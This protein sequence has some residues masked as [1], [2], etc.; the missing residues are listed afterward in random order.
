MQTPRLLL[1]PCV[2]ASTPSWADEL[3]RVYAGEC[4]IV[5]ASDRI[6][7]TAYVVSAQIDLFD[8]EQFVLVT[9]DRVDLAGLLDHL[10]DRERP[11]TIVLHISN[12]PLSD[13][14]HHFADLVVY[15]SETA[16]A[17]AGEAASPTAVIPSPQ[18]LRNLRPGSRATSPDPR[19]PLVLWP[20]DWAEENEPAVLL[21]ALD[22]L[23]SRGIEFRLALTGEHRDEVSPAI[24]TLLSR[25][26]EYIEVAEPL[27][28]EALDALLHRTDVVV[29]T[30]PGTSF[31]N[32][33]VE[34]MATGTYAVL[35]RRG[36][37]HELVPADLQSDCLFPVGGLA[38][39][40]MVALTLGERRLFIGRHLAAHARHF[41]ASQVAQRWLD[42]TTS[43][44]YPPQEAISSSNPVAPNKDLNGP[45]A[46]DT[47]P[48]DEAFNSDL[49]SLRGL[50]NLPALDAPLVESLEV[51]ESLDSTESLKVAETI[52][53][54]EAPEAVASAFTDFD[55]TMTFD[56][57][58]KV[59]VAQTEEA[60][61]YAELAPTDWDTAPFENEA[62]LLEQ[63]GSEPESASTSEVEPVKPNAP[64][65]WFATADER[66]EEAWS[67]PIV[68]SAFEFQVDERPARPSPGL[69]WTKLSG[70]AQASS[71]KP[72]NQLVWD[73][74]PITSAN[75]V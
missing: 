25:F 60:A 17:A 3:A 32:S 52:E 6:A 50:A 12:E 31:A 35:S 14:L 38:R 51:D 9:D 47:V 18:S 59:G 71:P 2:D 73:S 65:R 11:R 5:P 1:V 40:L 48:P 23:E 8:E 20:L 68:V 43:L 69:A 67:S 4:A 39:V 63:V 75:D 28:R 24:S 19:A 13:E 37:H 26:A 44:L 41:D 53:C 66:A 72:L 42:V 30:S 33:L 70:S 21:E 56:E 61:A 62:D 7:E 54:L 15:A 45:A 36:L 16:R 34:A 55:E 57:S 64:L 58:I 29:S 10:S 49:P 27:D 46:I 74:A 22:D